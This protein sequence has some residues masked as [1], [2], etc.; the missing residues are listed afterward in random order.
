MKA[1]LAGATGLIGSHCLQLLLNNNQYTAIEIWV[2]KPTGITHPKLTETVIN[3]DRILELSLANIQHVYC[4]MG[5]TINKAKTQAE[6]AK[7]DKQYVIDLAKLAEKSGCQRIFVV[8]SI[9][10]NPKSNNFYLKT[11]GEMEEGVKSTTIPSIY[12]LQPS[13]LL[14]KRNEYRFGEQIGKVIMPFFQLFLVGKYKKY[15]A[16]QASTVASAMMS[17]ARRND[18]GTFIL[19]S[20][21]IEMIGKS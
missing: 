18:N 15:K 10:A 17:L 21:E 12:I 16:I 3:F 13:M 9:G 4:C 14:G 20:N 5:T 6:F 2:R 19:E 1:L 7:V 8:S 11:K